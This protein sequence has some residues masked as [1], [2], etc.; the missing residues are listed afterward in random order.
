MTFLEAMKEE[1]TKKVLKLMPL[2][3]EEELSWEEYISK[4][5]EEQYEILFPQMK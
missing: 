1:K 3:G 2:M 4:S 5:I